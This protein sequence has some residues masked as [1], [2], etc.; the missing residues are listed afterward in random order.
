MASTR[1]VTAGQSKRA[2]CCRPASAQRARSARSAK[3]AERARQLLADPALRARCA[4]A[5]RQQAAR[6]DWPAVTARVLA[7]YDE[8]RG[9]A[10]GGARRPAA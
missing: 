5:G 3:L 9:A 4:E 8:L 6:F 7:I 10:G 1:A 2:A